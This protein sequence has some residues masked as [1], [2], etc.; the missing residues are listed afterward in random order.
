M[1]LNLGD[2]VKDEYT[3]FSGYLTER[4]VWLYGCARL[5]IASKKPG[6]EDMVFDEQ[7]VTKVK[8]KGVPCKPRRHVTDIELGDEVKDT[9]NGWTGVTVGIIAMINGTT[10]IVVEAT[11][12]DKDGAVT[13]A[14]VFHSER[15]V[16]IKKRKPVIAKEMAKAP[17]KPGGPQQDR[18]RSYRKR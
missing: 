15:L 5:C 18:I 17:E 14:K 7:R 16:I 13:P 6:T 9:L 4:T 10:E 3:G 2:P 8:G 12:L 11:K 1:P